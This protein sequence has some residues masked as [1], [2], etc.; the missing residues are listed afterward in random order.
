LSALPTAAVDD[1]RADPGESVGEIEGGQRLGVARPDPADPG[2]DA[3]DHHQQLGPEL[4]D[5][6]ALEGHQPGLEKD[7]DGEGDLDGRRFLAQVL[8]QWRHEQR[9]SVLEVRDGHHAEDAEEEDEPAVVAQ[10]VMLGN[11]GRIGVIRS[12]QLYLRGRRNRF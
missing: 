3:A 4:V 6:P 10:A 5:Q 7:E 9:P 8:L 2:E 12:H 1:A 11:R